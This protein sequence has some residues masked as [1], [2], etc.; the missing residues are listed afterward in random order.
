MFAFKHFVIV[1]ATLSLNLFKIFLL[2]LN[3]LIPMFLPFSEAVLRVSFV[4]V[5]QGGDKWEW[6]SSATQW[7]S[8]VVNTGCVLLHLIHQI[9]NLL[10]SGSSPKS[11]RSRKGNV[12]SEF[13]TPRQPQHGWRHSWNRTSEVLQI[14]AGVLYPVRSKWGRV[15]LVFFLKSILFQE[16]EKTRFQS[17]TI[18]RQQQYPHCIH[19]ALPSP[20]PE[21]KTSAFSCPNSTSTQRNPINTEKSLM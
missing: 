5:L 2:A 14:V 13:R 17:T 15:L 1:K 8:S 6:L 11:K 10:T 9:W 16:K 3:T 21:H 12:L 20:H 18:S 7:K 19:C 4:R